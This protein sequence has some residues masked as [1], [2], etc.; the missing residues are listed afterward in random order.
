MKIVIKHRGVPVSDAL[1]RRIEKY[2]FNHADDLRIDEAD[3]VVE[4]NWNGGPPFR[5]A[6]HIATPGLDV[7]AG[8][9]DQTLNAALLK[10]A[11]HLNDQV[12][13]RA[14]RQLGRGRTKR[15]TRA[16]HRRGMRR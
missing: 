13:G 2:L 6:V 5:V 7:T 15:Q 8:G 3:V 11:H 16:N 9:A 4:R 14:A 1:D 12:R 10:F